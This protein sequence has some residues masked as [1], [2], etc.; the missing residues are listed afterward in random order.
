MRINKEESYLLVV[1]A[2]KHACASGASD[3]AKVKDI[4]V[5]KGGTLS[6][7]CAKCIEK[8]ARENAADVFKAMADGRGEKENLKA[9]AGELV[10]IEATSMKMAKNGSEPLEVSS[11]PYD[12]YV[13][14]A[15]KLGF[16]PNAG[17]AEKSNNPVWRESDIHFLFE[18]MIEY[19]IEKHLCSLWGCDAIVENHL[20]EFKTAELKKFHSAIAKRCPSDLGYHS[21]P[22]KVSP[23]CFY[24]INSRANLDDKIV[25]E[26]KKRGAFSPYD[27]FI[28]KIFRAWFVEVSDERRK[29]ISASAEDEP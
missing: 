1:A 27:E 29:S 21:D 16:D 24:D 13:S 14:Q 19:A 5:R 4:I 17:E 28:R 23:D 10:A 11:V 6:A 22:K 8:D 18:S 12:S 7:R 26:L 2:F 3:L 9:K 15:K 25:D 20:D